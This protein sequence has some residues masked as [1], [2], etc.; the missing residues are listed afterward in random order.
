MN[1]LERLEVNQEFP[2]M[3]GDV[4]DGSVDYYDFNWNETV[5]IDEET[6]SCGCEQGKKA[7]KTCAQCSQHCTDPAPEPD[8][9]IPEMPADIDGPEYEMVEP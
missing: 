6:S 5:L 3:G 1:E 7:C 2:C 8:P 4:T 9:C